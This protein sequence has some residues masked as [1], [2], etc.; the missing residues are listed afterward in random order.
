M[1]VPPPIVVDADVLIRNVDYAV[2]KGYAGALLGQATRNY[3]LTGGIVLFAAVEAGGECVRHLPDIARS[4][5][6]DIAAV[7]AV[8]NTLFVPSVRFVKVGENDVDDARIDGVHPKDRPTARLAALLAPAVLTTDNRKHFRSFGLPET[9]TDAVALDLFA[10][11]QFGSGVQGV[12]VFPT[13]GGAATIEGS[14]K[15][16]AKVG[17]DASALIGFIVL[18]A[19]VLFLTS[20]RGRKLRARLGEIARDAAPP[21]AELMANVSAAGDRVGAFAISRIGDP[22]ALAVIAA[23]LATGQSVMTTR[24]VARELRMRGFGFEAG[25][26]ETETR[27]WLERTSC[28]NEVGRGRW[29]LGYHAATL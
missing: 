26:H 4:R 6:V 13:L 18:G 22:A 28:F 20:E 11:G 12:T 15:I 5:G 24:E 19:V 17:G 3:T 10:L 14:K 21:L 2:R 23:R 7:H 16:V 9:K 1:V 25:R 27:A 29:A 8:W